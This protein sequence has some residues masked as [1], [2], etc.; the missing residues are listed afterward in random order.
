MKKFYLLVFFLSGFL[1]LLANTASASIGVGVGTG[2]IKI[3]EPLK[4]GGIYELPDLPVLNTGSEAGDYEVTVEYHTGVSELRPAKA[5]F[6]FQPQEFFL[7]VSGVQPVGVTLTLPVKTPPG[8]YFC[9]LEAHPFKKVEGA[10]GNTRIKVAA[11]TKL[12]F[13]VEPANIFRG[14]Y[15]RAGAIFNK[16]RAGSYIAISVITFAILLIL[17]K[18]YFSV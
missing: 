10:D 2:K 12:Y 14:M 8:E 1:F 17:F 6:D 15:Y 9:Y 16:Y 13:T 5:W 11:A 18:K 3:D 7:D 4:A